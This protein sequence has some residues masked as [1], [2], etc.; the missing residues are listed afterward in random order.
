MCGGLMPPFPS[1]NFTHDKPAKLRR[2]RAGAGA[3]FVLPALITAFAHNRSRPDL[4][5]TSTN[6]CPAPTG[7]IAT[8]LSTPVMRARSVTL[9]A[10]PM[11]HLGLN[12]AIPSAVRFGFRYPAICLACAANL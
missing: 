11:K 12:L 5:R 2:E 8:V 3:S 10:S 1:E 6:P 9:R 4:T 7:N